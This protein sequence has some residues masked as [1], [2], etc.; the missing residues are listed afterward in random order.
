LALIEKGKR[1]Y[2]GKPWDKNKGRF[3]AKKKGMTHPDSYVNRNVE[4]EYCGKPRHLAKYC[5]RRKNH[6]SN[7]IYK[8]NNGNY[9]HKDTSVNDDFKNIK[10]FIFEVLLS[11]ETD[12]ENACS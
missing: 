3:Q 11:V 2:R 1:S 10:L 9:V 8:R 5:Y 12:D 4:C 6:E 7:Q